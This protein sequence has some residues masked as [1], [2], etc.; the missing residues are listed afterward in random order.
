MATA[1]GLS[2]YIVEI[3]VVV[4]NAEFHVRISL[5]NIPAPLNTP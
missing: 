3:D 1:V 2:F 4:E 5:L